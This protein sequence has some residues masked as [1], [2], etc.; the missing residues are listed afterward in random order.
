MLASYY[1][2]GVAYLSVAWLFS[3]AYPAPTLP[4]EA[5]KVEQAASAPKV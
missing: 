3:L 1:I 5:P 4:D 2:F